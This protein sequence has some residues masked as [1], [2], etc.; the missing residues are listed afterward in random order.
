MTKKDFTDLGVSEELATKAAEASKKELESYVQKSKYDLVVTEKETLEIQI[1]E[2]CKQLE[3]LKKAAKGSEELEKKV[4]EL[5]D[6]AAASKAKY[7]KQINDIQLNH[8]IDTALKEAKAKN[9]KAVRSLLDMENIVLDDGKVKGLDKQIKKLQEAEDS[10]F[11]FESAPQP[12]DGKPKIGGNTDNANSSG[13][14]NGSAATD[15]GSD[16]KSI[17]Q[18]MAE[19]YNAD[20]VPA[21]DNK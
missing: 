17:G 13:I 3:E 15:D 5:Q 1:K 2:H 14:G 11:L 4:K 12:E 19:A 21:A 10:K 6:D 9:A 20:H 18:L 8:A 7:E 16:S